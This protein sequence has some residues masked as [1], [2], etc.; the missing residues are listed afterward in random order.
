MRISVEHW[1][2]V[3]IKLERKM[4]VVMKNA[5]IFLPELRGENVGR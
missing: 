2:V 4:G 1:M 5:D 3:S